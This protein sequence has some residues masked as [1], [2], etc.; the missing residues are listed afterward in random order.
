[1]EG[2]EDPGGLDKVIGNLFGKKFKKKRK[3]STAFLDIFSAIMEK[4]KSNPKNDGTKMF[5][6]L[7]NT[8]SV[9]K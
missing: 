4:T 5:S 7:L 3:N 9:L 6:S 2:N 1:M 8:Q